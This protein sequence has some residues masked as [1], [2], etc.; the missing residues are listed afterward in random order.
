MPEK[1]HNDG[2]WFINVTR[3][4]WGVKFLDM[5][6]VTPEWPLYKCDFKYSYR[7]GS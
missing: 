2:E 6:Y 1:K 5:R 4:W 3:G 7:N